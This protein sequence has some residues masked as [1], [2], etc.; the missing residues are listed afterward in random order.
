MRLVDRGIRMCRLLLLNFHKISKAT[1]NN[2]LI[3]VVVLK[4]KVATIRG[5]TQQSRSNVPRPKSFVYAPS[6]ALILVNTHIFTQE[7]C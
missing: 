6:V 1:P 7:E 5:L 3:V 4:K 2:I